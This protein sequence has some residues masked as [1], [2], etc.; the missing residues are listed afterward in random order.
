MLKPRGEHLYQIYVLCKEC[1]AAQSFLGYDLPYKHA[2]EWLNLI[3]QE[4][5]YEGIVCVLNPKESSPSSR[6][7]LSRNGE[8]KRR[9][10]REKNDRCTMVKNY[11]N[12]FAKNPGLRNLSA[13]LDMVIELAQRHPAFKNRCFN[14]YVDSWRTMLESEDSPDFQLKS[15]SFGLE[16]NRRLRIYPA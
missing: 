11:I 14:P 6:K 13:L 12:I 1:H 2:F 8:A 15:L 3:Y 16:P 10:L 7:S 5:I 4:L 9:I